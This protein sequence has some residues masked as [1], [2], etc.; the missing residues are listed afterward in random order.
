MLLFCV[1]LSTSFM[2]PVS[3]STTRDP[4]SKTFPGTQ[5]LFDHHHL[6]AD[7]P[8]ISLISRAP[9]VLAFM[10]LLECQLE[11]LIFIEGY[12][13]G[14]VLNVFLLLSHAILPIN[15]QSLWAATIFL[16]LFHRWR[17][18]GTE[19]LSCLPNCLPGPV[20]GSPWSLIWIWFQIYDCGQCWGNCCH[21]AGV[22]IWASKCK[23]YRG[24]IP[25]WPGSPLTVAS[26][27]SRGFTT[28]CVQYLEYY[29]T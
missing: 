6:L 2:R 21:I 7:W 22:G 4:E 11:H 28:L 26:D 10:L 25:S 14:T 23:V 18:W 3:F 12:L 17:N 15:V 8:I 19:R 27:L 9:H 5:W 16:S 20:L 24:P 29:F 13:S 1:P